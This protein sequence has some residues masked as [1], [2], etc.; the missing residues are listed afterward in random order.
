MS[1]KKEVESYPVTMYECPYCGSAY[2]DDEYWAEDC[3]DNC[4]KKLKKENKDE[5]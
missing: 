1:E 2:E 3:R 5:N 4:Y